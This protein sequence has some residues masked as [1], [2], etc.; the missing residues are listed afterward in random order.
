[1]ANVINYGGLAD[2]F[3]NSPLY[4]PYQLCDSNVILETSNIPFILA[5]KPFKYL[6]PLE[7]D[8]HTFK[9][10]DFNL[11]VPRVLIHLT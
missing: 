8:D 6:C 2:F 4:S 11:Q 1:M 9:V 5:R 10:D 3:T 7:N